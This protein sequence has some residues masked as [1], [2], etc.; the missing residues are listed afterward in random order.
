MTDLGTVG[1]QDSMTED[2]VRAA[3]KPEEEQQPAEGERQVHEEPKA[4]TEED[5]DRE[6]EIT[7][8]E[9][10]TIWML[11][12]PSTIVALDADDAEDVKMKNDRYQEVERQCQP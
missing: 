3:T 7:L 1:P 10:D 9:T 2:L 11:D 8:S 4:L 6:V 12:I 5:L